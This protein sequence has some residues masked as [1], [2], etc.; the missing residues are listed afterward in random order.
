MGD[1]PPYPDTNTNNTGGG[2]DRES[3]TSAPRWAKVFGIIFIVVV[4]LLVMSHHVAHRPRPWS[5]HAFR[6]PWWPHTAL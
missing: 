2:A 4:L 1:P 6:W 3:T 5:P